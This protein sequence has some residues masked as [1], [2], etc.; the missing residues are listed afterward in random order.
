MSLAASESRRVRSPHLFIWQRALPLRRSWAQPVAPFSTQK[1]EG[2][3]GVGG[4]P[5]IHLFEMK[6]QP[7]FLPHML[8]PPRV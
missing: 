4:E 1:Y 5:E 3:S 7:A 2:F 8:T 6:E